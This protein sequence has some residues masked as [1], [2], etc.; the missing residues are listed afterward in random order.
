M[1]SI[2]SSETVSGASELMETSTCESTT[3][4]RNTFRINF[5]VDRDRPLVLDFVSHL[6]TI[7]NRW[8]G[9]EFDTNWRQ[10]APL[11]KIGDDDA[12]LYPYPTD[13]RPFR[14][15]NFGFPVSGN[16]Q[17]FH[18]PDQTIDG[19]ITVSQLVEAVLVLNKHAHNNGHH[20]QMKQF[21]GWTPIDPILP[22]LR[23]YRK[24]CRRDRKKGSSSL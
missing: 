19:K 22:A 9:G 16:E 20:L 15:L 21:I 5:P 18:T 6:K 24:Q 13:G 11:F 10:L 12:T 7:L 1:S 3:M 14:D 4:C 8:N 2:S 23:A 17:Y